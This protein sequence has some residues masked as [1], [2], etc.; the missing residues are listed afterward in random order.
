MCKVES[1]EFEKKID[2]FDIMNKEAAQA[3]KLGMGRIKD[4]WVREFV[5]RGQSWDSLLQDILSD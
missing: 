2:H 3:L 1:L 5:Q 4:N